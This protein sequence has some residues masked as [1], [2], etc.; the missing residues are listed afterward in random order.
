V[1]LSN[2]QVE[3]VELGGDVRERRPANQLIGLETGRSAACEPSGTA[4]RGGVG[5]ASRALLGDKAFTRR[6]IL[7]GK[8]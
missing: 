1:E 5:A 2:D 3:P 4:Q 6:T 8:Q 7:A